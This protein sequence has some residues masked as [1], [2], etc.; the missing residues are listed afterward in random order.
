MSTPEVA[1]A[2]IQRGMLH[3][4]D[5]DS[6]DESERAVLLDKLALWVDFTVNHRVPVVLLLYA[7]VFKPDGHMEDRLDSAKADAD[8]AGGGAGAGDAKL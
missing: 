5:A 8:S 6:V 7:A 1:A 3:P 4:G 2:C